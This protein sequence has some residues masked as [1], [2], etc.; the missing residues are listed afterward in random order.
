MTL[1]SN[2]N[3]PTFNCYV[4]L[5]SADTYM[6]E[7]L[8]TE[9]WDDAEDSNKEAAL[10]WSTK[11]LD[12]SFVWNGGKRSITQNLGWPRYGTYDGDGY[13]LNSDQIPKQLRIA[14]VEYA[15]L[16]L[17]TDR[18]KFYEPSS[19]GL[20]S[21]SLGSISMS[22]DKVDKPPL[23]SDHVRSI[24][25]GLFSVTKTPSTSVMVVRT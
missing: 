17:S 5:A 16:L 8:H 10:I 25:F 6:T 20:N 2:P 9:V 21:L 13:Y 22:F 14:T 7:R 11:L 4:S 24:L 12:L 18:T 19:Q 1:D 15:L 23:I 3:S